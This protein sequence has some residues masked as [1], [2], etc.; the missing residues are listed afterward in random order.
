MPLNFNIVELA[1]ISVATL[2]I[3]RFEGQKYLTIS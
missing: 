1:V 3:K 2:Q